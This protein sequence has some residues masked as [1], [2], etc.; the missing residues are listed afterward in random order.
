MKQKKNHISKH[1]EYTTQWQKCWA[2]LHR[3][4]WH[5]ECCF[6][7]DWRQHY[8]NCTQ[9]PPS[10]CC[11]CK[12]I[13]QYCPCKS[14]WNKAAVRTDLHLKERREIQSL[15]HTVLTDQT[16]TRTDLSQI[17]KHHPQFQPPNGDTS[18]V[19]AKGQGHFWGSELQLQWVEWAEGEQRA[20]AEAGRDMQVTAELVFG[21]HRQGQSIRKNL[22]L[23]L[24]RWLTVGTDA[25]QFF[26]KVASSI[27]Q[28]N[29]L[30]T[31]HIRE[32]ENLDRYVIHGSRKAEYSLLLR[33]HREVIRNVFYLPTYLL[34]KSRC[35]E[36][37]VIL[38]L[39]EF[40]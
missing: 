1:S 27:R 29:I 25:P 31:Y 14:H 35:G 40:F 3:D 4:P 16:L 6:I 24:A 17:P 18:M 19:P 12:K 32:N 30:C 13:F 8:H 34:Q 11:K 20:K 9:A 33:K 38:R 5:K 21:P 7:V 37:K 39:G 26:R 15:H 2:L 28:K 22:A 10:L 36:T 23:A